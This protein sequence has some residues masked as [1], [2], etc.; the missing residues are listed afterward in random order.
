MR[1]TITQDFDDAAAAAAFL[2]KVTG[3]PAAPS[4]TPA[5]GGESSVGTPPAVPVSPIGDKP[6]R[7]KRADAG[8][9]REPYGPRTTTGEP[10]EK[11]QQDGTDKAVASAPAQSALPVSPT[12]SSAPAKSPAEGDKP[13]PSGVPTAPVAEEFPATLEG[14]RKAMKALDGTKG[15]G[16]EACI[17]ALKAHGV[18]RI[19]DLKAEQ[20][21]P[22]IKD[23]LVDSSAEGIE[24]ARKWAGQAAKK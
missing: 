14:A 8:Q 9:P 6:A 5:G 4:V 17:A 13:Q 22:F 1:I 19:S 2:A 23:V 20:F 7:K 18:N 16:M 3:Q 21:A 11:V 15:K 24:T 10:A 12:T